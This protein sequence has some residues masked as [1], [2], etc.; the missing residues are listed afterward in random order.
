M[1]SSQPEKTK[2]NRRGGAS[3]ADTA[4]TIL[5]NGCQFNGRLYCR[6]S[7]RIGGKI[8]GQLIS[9][10]LLIIE[11]D[12]L[13]LAEIQAEEVIIQ[14]RVKG[15]LTANVRVELCASSE[16]EGDIATPSLIINEGAQFNG[17]AVMKPAADQID[18]KAAPK[19]TPLDMS[20]KDAKGTPQDTKSAQM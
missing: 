18:R 4:V 10:G 2:K 16:F 20:P 7:S 6:G 1:F 15:S 5:T 11:D 14:G 12:A 9:D 17:S 13:I 19:V 3:G 8:E